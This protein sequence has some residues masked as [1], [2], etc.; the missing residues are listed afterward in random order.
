[1]DSAT[2][3][4]TSTPGSGAPRYKVINGGGGGGGG[5]GGLAGLYERRSGDGNKASIRCS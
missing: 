1:V 2:R 3:S 4:S 5:G